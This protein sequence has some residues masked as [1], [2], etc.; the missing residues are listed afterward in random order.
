[1][2]NESFKE[3]LTEE[4]GL[5]AR[6]A[7]DVLSRLNRGKSF[8]DY[9]SAMPIDEVLMLL[10]RRPDFISLTRS[11]KSQIRR[12]LRLHCEYTLT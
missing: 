2:D 1:M 4:K 8:I 6:V 3:W 9:D 12:A 10:E 5:S 11:V 7:K